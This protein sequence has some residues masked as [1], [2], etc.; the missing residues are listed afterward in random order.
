[1][2][3]IFSA[4]TTQIPG[5]CMFLLRY[6]GRFDRSTWVSMEV[7]KLVYNLLVGGIQPTCTGVK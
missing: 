4:L 5:N 2:A 6:L 1:M 7:S 3:L